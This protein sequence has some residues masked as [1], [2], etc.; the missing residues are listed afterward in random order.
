M[1]VLHGERRLEGSLGKGLLDA[2][3]VEGLADALVDLLQVHPGQAAGVGRIGAGAA[4]ADDEDEA[5]GVAGD[6]R[7]QNFPRVGVG[8]IDRAYRNYGGALMFQPGIDGDDDDLLLGQVGHLG[9]EGFEDT[10]R[11]VQG[12]QVDLFAGDAGAEFKSGG[13]LGC[14]GHTQ[15]LFLGKCG[16]RHAA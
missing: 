9:A 14:F 2:H 8:F 4:A 11:G 10:F 13:E 12:Q 15:A 7:A 1:P 6:D 3:L 16:Y 5:V